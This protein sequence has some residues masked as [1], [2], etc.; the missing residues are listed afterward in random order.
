VARIPAARNAQLIPTIPSPANTCR[1][2]SQAENTASIQ[3]HPQ[4]L[5]RFQRSVCGIRTRRARVEA[6]SAWNCP[7]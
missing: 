6:S 4:Y 7:R 5:A 3:I 2:R 1:G